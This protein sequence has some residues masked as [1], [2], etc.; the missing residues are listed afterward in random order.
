MKKRALLFLLL[1]TGCVEK[2]DFNISRENAGVVIESYIANMSYNESLV[3]P[4]DGEHF[5]VK[6]S[7]LSD[8]DNIRDEK[9]EDASVFL[10][11]SE[12]NEWKYTASNVIPGEYVLFSNDFKAKQG[13]NYQLNV[14]L[15]GGEHFESSWETLPEI[16]NREVGDFKIEE[17]RTQ[18]YVYEAGEPV[19]K[20][21]DGVNV[22]IQIPENV[23]QEKY[24]YRWSFDPL[25]QYTAELAD[26]VQSERVICWVRNNFY[27]KDFVLQ[28]DRNGGSLKELFFLKIK[29]NER[30]FQYF[31]TLVNQDILSDGYYNFWKELNAQKDKGGL[32]DQPPFGLTTNF[33]A[34]NNEWT[35]NGYFGVVA[36]SS[37]RWTL[38]PKELS[39]VIDNTILETC[40]LRINEPGP[41]VDQCYFCDAYNMGDA[42]VTPP[43]WWNL[44]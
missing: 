27:Q 10:I 12:G 5:R 2:F 40:E 30:A 29:G 17:E 38:D 14:V 32:F 8:V 6:V 34:T 41:K 42:T 22:S 7:Q 23:N 11:D 9:I 21:I 43:D 31:S 33:K 1:L 28:E 25:W 44:R 39:Y 35:V 3:I 4:S 24:N 20:D 16:G 18:E 15:S 13:V 19:V 37:K 36:R 26:V